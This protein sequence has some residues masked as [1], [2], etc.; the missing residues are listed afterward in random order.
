[1]IRTAGLQ[2]NTEAMK[3][4][5]LIRCRWSFLYLG[6]NNCLNLETVS[7]IA[8]VSRT[9]DVYPVPDSKCQ[10]QFCQW[11]WTAILRSLAFSIQGKPHNHHLILHILR[12]FP[13]QYLRGTSSLL[14]L[15][16]RGLYISSVQVN[17]FA[18]WTVDKRSKSPKAKRNNKIKD[19]PRQE[20]EREKS[21]ED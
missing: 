4:L 8:K 12:R 5:S 3:V 2:G 15:C 10:P 17:P 6:S 19:G 14:E 16:V 21:G 7:N 18:T 20:R 11:V 9:E 1:M 13:G